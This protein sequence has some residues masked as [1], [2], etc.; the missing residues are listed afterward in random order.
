MPT[1]TDIALKN[2]AIAAIV[3]GY[4]GTP[5]DVLGVHP[6]SAD[7]TEGLVIRAFLPQ[8]QSVSVQRGEQIYPMERVHPEGFFEVALLGETEFFPYRLA[9]TLPDGRTYIAEDPYRFGPVLTE[10]DLYL[11]GEGNH[12][13]L[14]EKLGAHLVEH[15][16]VSGVVFAVWAPNAQRVSV[17]GD[18][19]EWDGRRHPMRPR[20]AIGLWELFLPGLKQGD[21]YKYDILTPYQG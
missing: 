18:F 9:I 2:G 11:F 17:V 20:G 19:N 7:G 12:F 10:Y 4:H 5:F 3:G 13:E 21:L 14:Y 8:A 6:L 15:E 16:G 1:A